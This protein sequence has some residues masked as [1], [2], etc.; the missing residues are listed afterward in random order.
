MILTNIYLA[1]PKADTCYNTQVTIPVAP[2]FDA[3]A[4]S[5]FKGRLLSFC[6]VFFALSAEAVFFAAVDGVA[7]L[8]TAA[9]ETFRIFGEDETSSHD[10]WDFIDFLAHGELVAVRFL[11]PCNKQTFSTK[12]LIR[13][14]KKTTETHTTALRFWR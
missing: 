10:S 7:C 6:A 1:S 4:V 2:S 8:A 14:K 13:K 3:A 9:A 12:L 5:N 11:P